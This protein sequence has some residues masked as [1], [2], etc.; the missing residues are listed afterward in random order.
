M[1]LSEL[2]RIQD[3]LEVQN[4]EL[5]KYLH[6]IELIVHD[7]NNIFQIINSNIELMLMENKHDDLDRIENIGQSIDSASNL[8][9]QLQFCINKLNQQA[10][11]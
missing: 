7:F 8:L 6:R 2:I 9:H 11:Y 3:E 5:Q 1:A 4:K 10:V